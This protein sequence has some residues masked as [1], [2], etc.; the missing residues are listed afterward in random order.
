MGTTIF[1]TSILSAIALSQ[2]ILTFD[3]ATFLTYLFTI[4][5][6]IIA[7]I[8]EMQKCYEWYIT[9]FL[10]YALYFQKK[11]EEEQ[12]KAKAEIQIQKE[13]ENNDLQIQ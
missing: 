5:G 11:C 1:I 4:I 6:G 3:I 2:A 9:S 7:G 13:N 12:E 8:L 10:D